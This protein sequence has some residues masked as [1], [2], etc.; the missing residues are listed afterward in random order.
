MRVPAVIMLA[1]FLLGTVQAVVLR[2][3]TH[4]FK[5][6]EAA[7]SGTLGGITFA[8]NHTRYHAT[9]GVEV[10]EKSSDAG[11]SAITFSNKTH[12]KSSTVEA[13]AHT[14]TVSGNG[15]IVKLNRSVACVR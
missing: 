2:P 4:S 3:S 14:H 15:V 5:E 6:L 10:S 11:V 7:C 12:S 13:N 8:M 1:G 9:P